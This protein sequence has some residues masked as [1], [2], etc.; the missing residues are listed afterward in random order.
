M[1][2]KLQWYRV[3]A[4]QWVLLDKPPAYVYKP[5]DGSQ[6]EPK[7]KTGSQRRRERYKK[8]YGRVP[9]SV[10]PQNRISRKDKRKLYSQHS[11]CFW[12]G[13]LNE[14]VDHLIPR[15]FNAL[16]TRRDSTYTNIHTI[17]NLVPCCRR[18]NSDKA[19]LLPI[20]FKRMKGI[21]F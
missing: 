19:A 18:C 7:K 20:E 10:F 15:S 16:G 21:K 6:W 11:K 5:P 14:S 9:S 2:L 4:T 8:Q 12:C 1:A 3:S 13:G 17:G